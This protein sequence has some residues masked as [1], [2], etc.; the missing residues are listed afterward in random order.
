M[1][2]HAAA[3]GPLC[4]AAASKL[5]ASHKAGGMRDRLETARFR[6]QELLRRSEIRDW[7]ARPAMIGSEQ[8]YEVCG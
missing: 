6:T 3:G 8:S 7:Q 2:M 4:I 1:P 5:V